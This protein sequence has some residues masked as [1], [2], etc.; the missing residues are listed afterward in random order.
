METL[1][2][3]CL[4]CVLYTYGGYPVAVA[5]V[6]RVWGRPI[7]PGGRFDGSA[8]VVVAAYNEES[9]I[10][11]RLDELAG[12]VAA[13]GRDGEVIV[14]S[15]G[16]TDRT[17]E[18]ARTRAAGDPRIR[19]VELAA[20]QGKAA[21][22]AGGWAAAGSEIVAFAGARQ[23]RAPDALECLLADFTDP[24]VGAVSGDLIVASSPGVMAGVG[25]Y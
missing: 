9:T 21:A 15:D 25:L 3:A 5:C 10:G 24:A 22:V 2:W 7:R 20:N 1:F 12:L 17:A 14:V 16:S 19:V 8:S 6:A 11:R 18:I 23:S 4:A 13:S